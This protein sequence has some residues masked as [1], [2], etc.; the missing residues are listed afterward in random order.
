MFVLF[1]GGFGGDFHKS[2]LVK[3]LDIPLMTLREGIHNGLVALIHKALDIVGTFTLRIKG[4]V[5]DETEG[6][7]LDKGK[8][9]LARQNVEG[10]IDGHRDNGELQAVGKLETTATEEAHVTGE[11]ASTL[12]EDAEGGTSAENIACINHRLGNGAAA[13]FVDRNE[14]GFA[15]GHAYKG[16]IE[17]T[18]LHH[19]LEFVMQEGIDNKY[20][21]SA[22]MIG[23]KDV[24]LVLLHILATFDS[25]GDKQQTQNA[26]SPKTPDV[27]GAPTGAAHK[28]RKGY[29]KTAQEGNEEP[30]GEDDDELIKFVKHG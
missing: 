12:G 14:T 7:A 19:P 4:L 16:N 8:A 17:E 29:A 22:L 27:G 15:A 20:V 2:L 30:D 11:G 13:A 25:D 1:F 10:A 21:E 23:H 9:L 3:I 18:L 26:P 24:T 28:R 5:D 6:M